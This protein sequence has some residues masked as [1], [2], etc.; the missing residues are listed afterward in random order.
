[1]GVVAPVTG[2]VAAALPV[3]VGAVRDGL[4]GPALLVG[5][6]LALAAV[7]V[8]S[9]VAGADGGRSGIEFGILGGVGFAVFN[10]LVGFLPDDA[11]FSPLVPLKIGAATLIVLVVIGGK[12]RWTVPR[13]VLPLALGAAVLDLSGIAFYVLATQAGRLDVAVTLSSLYPVTTVILAAVVLRER[14]TRDHWM[15]IALAA[16]AI[17][18]IASGSTA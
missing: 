2:L 13:S 10:I 9:R 5:I 11:V 3:L 7:V 14:V 15:G 17:V 8:V 6:V 12:R 1:M 18:L 4:P 16:V